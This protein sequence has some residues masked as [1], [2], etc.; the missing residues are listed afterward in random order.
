M[1]VKRFRSQAKRCAALA[2]Q[3]HDEESRQRFMKLER[4]Y[5]QL[6]ETEEQLASQLSALAGAREPKRVDTP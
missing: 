3:T 5:L 4:T 2:K 6:A 1:T